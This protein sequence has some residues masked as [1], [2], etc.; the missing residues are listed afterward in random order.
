[1]TRG[2]KRKD[3]GRK[4]RAR[5]PATKR[6]TLRLT[7]EEYGKIGSACAELNMPVAEYIRNHAMTAANWACALRCIREAR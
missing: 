6:V 7:L 5:K 4:P 3:A 1:M 2:G